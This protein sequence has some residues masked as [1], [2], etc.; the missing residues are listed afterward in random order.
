MKRIRTPLRTRA[1]A[2]GVQMLSSTRPDGS[3]LV[4]EATNMALPIHPG[5]SVVSGRI[6]TTGPPQLARL[7]LNVLICG[8]KGR[9]CEANLQIRQ[10]GKC[11]K[12]FSP[13]IVWTSGHHACDATSRFVPYGIERFQL[14]RYWC[15]ERRLEHNA[16]KS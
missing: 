6:D 1:G 3:E 11:T 9:S 2:S 13:H 16:L 4:T 14:R 10:R 15:W 12:T 5:G 8:R 7:H